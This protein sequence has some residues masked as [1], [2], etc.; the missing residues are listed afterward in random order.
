MCQL[1]HMGKGPNPHPM[2]S[3]KV[4]AIIEVPLTTQ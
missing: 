2:N 3:A 4:P 1:M